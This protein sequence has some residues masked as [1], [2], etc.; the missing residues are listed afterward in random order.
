MKHL[1]SINFCLDCSCTWWD[2]WHL[3]GCRA[4]TA[5]QV[6]REPLAIESSPNIFRTAFLQVDEIPFTKWTEARW[7]IYICFVVNYK[8]FLKIVLKNTIAHHLSSGRHLF[9]PLPLL[10]YGDLMCDR[11]CLHSEMS[12]LILLMRLHCSDRITSHLNSGIVI[13]GSGKVGI[14]Y[15]LHYLRSSD[16]T[17]HHS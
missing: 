4:L 3:T 10:C 13:S 11:D 6:S 1:G 14:S 12:T 7:G 5:Q 16:L 9:P 8:E 2:L 17:E 15:Q